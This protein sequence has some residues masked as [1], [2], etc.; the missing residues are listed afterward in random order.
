MKGMSGM[1]YS[2]LIKMMEKVPP[3][4][5]PAFKVKTKRYSEKFI[6]LNPVCIKSQVVYYQ[7]ITG[8]EKECLLNT[9][10]DPCLNFL[11]KCD[12]NKPSTYVI[13]AN[14]K[15]SILK[16]EPYTTYFGVKLFSIFGMSGWKYSPYK[17]CSN[18]IDL[19]DI[20]ETY[21]IEEII[22]EA[23]SFEE[24][25]NLFGNHYK[26]HWLDF[27]YKT[28]LIEYCSI[29]MCANKGKISMDAIENM[30]GYSKG[31]C[32][33]KFESM[34]NTSPKKYGRMIRFQM[35]LRMLLDERHKYDLAYIA[36]ENGYY[37]QAH[38]N[39]D[40]KSF[41]SLTPEK[42]K[43]QLKFSGA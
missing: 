34:Y 20:L 39:N 23:N 27:D 12:S 41:I 36:H 7:I 31:Y 13:G 43:K 29:L 32:R 42:L 37:D 5:Q 4:L 18:S 30:T 6:S 25:V 26:K 28:D 22:A 2:D 40:F 17:L 38:F 24:R 1:K 19:K 33:R 3:T 21:G 8:S 15:E 14:V 16:L 11:F 35:S 9:V 10:P